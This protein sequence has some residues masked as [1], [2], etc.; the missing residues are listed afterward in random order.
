MS[1]YSFYMFGYCFTY[2][3][4]LLGWFV[5]NLLCF[6]S[7]VEP[8]VEEVQTWQVTSW[9]NHFVTFYL[10]SARMFPAGS[11]KTHFSCHKA[12]PIAATG[13]EILFPNYVI[14][15]DTYASIP[16]NKFYSSIPFRLRI[17]DIILLFNSRFD[18]LSLWAFCYSLGLFLQYL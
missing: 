18:Y 13:Y 12:V 2:V 10:H 17:S 16:Q 6:L 14:S 15:L 1:F 9:C 7:L 11:F 5:V 4:W 3:I 8:Q